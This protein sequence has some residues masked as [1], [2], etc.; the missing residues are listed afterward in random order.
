MQYHLDLLWKTVLTS[1]ALV[2]CLLIIG[3][4]ASAQTWSLT[5]DQRRA[6]L[7]YYA[8]VIVKRGDENDGKQGRD[9]I[10]NSTLTRTTTSQPTA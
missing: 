10:T 9:W 6:Y 8:P 1:F 7:N 2:T 5:N 4:Q 3:V